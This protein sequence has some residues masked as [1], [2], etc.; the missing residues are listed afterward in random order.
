[1][2]KKGKVKYGSKT[3]REGRKRGQLERGRKGKKK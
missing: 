3:K 1:V 2:G